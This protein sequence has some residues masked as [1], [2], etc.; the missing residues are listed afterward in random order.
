MCSEFRATLEHINQTRRRM[1]L[2]GPAYSTALGEPSNGLPRVQAP[3]YPPSCSTN[4]KPMVYPIHD[5]NSSAHQPLPQQPAAATGSQIHI[6]P[7][8]SS[9]PIRHVQQLGQYGKL[10]QCT[11]GFPID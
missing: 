5:P 3:S 7:A 9:L 10:W 4:S 1:I 2:P 11:V 6:G 8:L